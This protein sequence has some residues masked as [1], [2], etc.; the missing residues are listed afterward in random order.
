MI[1]S[2]RVQCLGAGSD[3]A[4]PEDLLP[5]QDQ[6]NLGNLLYQGLSL[7]GLLLL[8]AASTGA[9]FPNATQLPLCNGRPTRLDPELA[10][11][12][13]SEWQQGAIAAATAQRKCR[14][15]VKLPAISDWVLMWPTAH[16]S[17]L[18]ESADEGLS[19]YQTWNETSDQ[20][21]GANTA[22]TAVRK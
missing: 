18:Q 20:R 3:P 1:A 8:P 13:P 11:T 16:I 7:Q 9:G 21:L 12:S 4:G 6:A 2:K 22:A 10:Y 15:G 17:Q 5:Q 14:C 19:G